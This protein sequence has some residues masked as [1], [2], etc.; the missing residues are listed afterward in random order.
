LGS[1]SGRFSGRSLQEDFTVKNRVSARLV[2]HDPIL[3]T[4]LNAIQQ[5]QAEI[6]ALRAQLGQPPL[7]A[8][9]D[10]RAGNSGG[11]GKR[12]SRIWKR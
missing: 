1:C 2:N 11:N 3:W 10:P 5:Q 9:I 4:M 6:R 7:V 8:K 12:G